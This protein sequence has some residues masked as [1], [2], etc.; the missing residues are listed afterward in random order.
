MI[1]LI[2]ISVD[3]GCA[4]TRD[5]IREHKLFFMGMKVIIDDKEY[6]DDFDFTED[7]FYR[8]VDNS[9]EFH[10]A[11]PPLG[12]VLEY[13]NDIRSR[14]YTELLDIH[15]SSKMSGLF[16]TCLMASKMVEGIDVRVVD[17]KKVSIGAN[18]VARKLIKLVESGSSLDEV[19]ESVPQVIDNTF[20]EFSVP[21]LKYLIKNGR[22]GKAQGLAGTLLNIKPILS[23]D[24]DGLISPIAK[25]RGMKKLQ[26]QMVLNIV[27]FL[28]DRRKSITLYSIYGSEEYLAVMDET[29]E[30]IIELIESSLGIRRDDIELVRGRIWPTIACHSGPAV[31]GLA[32]YGEREAE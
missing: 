12:Q 32:C 29:T 25:L 18:L 27:E 10:T 1:D 22:I 2:A 11:Q 24:K 20:M 28:H 5:F 15:F 6:T 13:Y 23:V 31:F 17:T 14:G 9:K 7:V 4:P 26:E 3:S 19:F 16:D 30:K 8:I 21:T